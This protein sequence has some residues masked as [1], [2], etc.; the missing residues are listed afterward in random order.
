MYSRLSARGV[1]RLSHTYTHKQTQLRFS[2]YIQ[3]VQKHTTAPYCY[4]T[5]VV[6]YLPF[7]SPS[8]TSPPGRCFRKKE[9]TIAPYCYMLK[10]IPL[11]SGSLLA[12]L[13]PLPP[14]GLCLL[15][16]NPPFL[17]HDQV[18]SVGFGASVCSFPACHAP[19]PTS[20][21]RFHGL[22]V[23]PAGQSSRT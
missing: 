18:E 22:H 15:L 13:E 1:D 8:S 5:N 11:P 16:W 20:P 21:R 6:Y 9:H 3:R 19:L 4:K 7:R 2:R 23:R 10:R 14:P 12:T 17:G